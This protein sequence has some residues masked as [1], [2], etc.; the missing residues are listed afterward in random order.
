MSKKDFKKDLKHLGIIY[1]LV[2]LSSGIV[3]SYITISMNAMR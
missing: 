3:Y 2:I 1:G